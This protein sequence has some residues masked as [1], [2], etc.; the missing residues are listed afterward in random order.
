MQINIEHLI[1]CKNYEAT[2]VKSGIIHL[3]QGP[4]NL[5]APQPSSL[6]NFHSVSTNWSIF[7]QGI[8]SSLARTC[9]S[10]LPAFQLPPQRRS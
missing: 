8:Q 9:P 5:T 6:A 1:I 7:A 3:N 10:P 2:L 4:E